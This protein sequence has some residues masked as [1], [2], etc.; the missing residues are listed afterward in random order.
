LGV[1]ERRVSWWLFGQPIALLSVALLLVWLSDSLLWLGLTVGL[2]IAHLIG[3][4]RISGRTT[5]LPMSV[6]IVLCDL[7]IANGLAG[8]FAF[9][10]SLAGIP[11]RVANVEEAIWG[12]G[13]AFTVFAVP[14]AAAAVVV[15]I[16]LQ[17]RLKHLESC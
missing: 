4:N 6:W 17:G 9:I 15:R 8:G 16:A 14:T 5:P 10:L 11:S 12:Y 13:I 2:L 1:E 3:G 7:F